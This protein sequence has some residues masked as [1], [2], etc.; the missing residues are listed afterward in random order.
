LL[1][2][3]FRQ[4]LQILGGATKLASLKLILTVDFD[5]IA[6]NSVES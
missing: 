5:E 2:Q 4:Q 1:D 3:P 6:R